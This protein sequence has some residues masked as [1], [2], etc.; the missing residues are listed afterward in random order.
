MTRVPAGQYSSGVTT[1]RP[2]A[3]ALAACLAGLS[4]AAC[5]PAG[6]DPDQYLADTMASALEHREATGSFPAWLDDMGLEKPGAGQVSFGRAQGGEVLCI[7]L[8]TPADDYSVY[9][10]APGVIVDGGCDMD[11]LA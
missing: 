9:S 8:T 7:S 4:L 11:R 2:A 3:A 1:F 10:D 6:P 5:V